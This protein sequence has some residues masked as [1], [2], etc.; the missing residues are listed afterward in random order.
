MI[1]FC[2]LKVSDVDTDGTPWAHY[3]ESVS[4]KIPVY[5]WTATLKK[6]RSSVSDDE[7]T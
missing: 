4:T 2:R 6:C 3:D 5:E 1:R 7:G